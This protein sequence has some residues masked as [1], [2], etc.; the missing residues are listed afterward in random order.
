MEYLKWL[1]FNGHKFGEKVLYLHLSNL[2]ISC[3]KAEVC[4]Q[5]VECFQTH[6]FTAL[7]M[8][9]F[10]LMPFTYDDC[11]ESHGHIFVEI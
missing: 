6:M 3:M 4:N 7:A 2:V 11:T 8:S 9:R 1:K 10:I 5:V